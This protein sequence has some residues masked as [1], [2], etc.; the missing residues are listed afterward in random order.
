MSLLKNC[1]FTIALLNI[2]T[3]YPMDPPMGPPIQRTYP[4]NFQPMQFADDPDDEKIIVPNPIAISDETQTVF[5]GIPVQDLETIFQAAPPKAKCIVK[6][7]KS[8]LSKNYFKRSFIVGDSGTGKTTLAK[9]IAYKVC[10][11]TPWRYEYI[12]S[13]TFMGQYRN[14]TGVCLRAYLK[15][16]AELEQPVFL[17]IDHLNRILEYTDSSSDD[18]SFASNLICSLI[19]R[20]EHNSNIYFLGVMNRATRL[21]KRLKSRMLGTMIHVQRP[22]SL[23]IDRIV[24]TSKVAGH[25]YSFDFDITHDWLHSLLVNNPEIRGRNY[26]GVMVELDAQ[27][28]DATAAPQDKHVITKK[29]LEM[30]IQKYLDSKKQIY[31]PDPYENFTDKTERLHTEGLF[32]KFLSSGSLELAKKMLDE[33]TFFTEDQEIIIQ[34]LLSLHA[35]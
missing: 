31:Y 16:I 23:E 18:T 29:R 20:Q 19:D 33:G 12:N 26:R 34:Q 27:S 13:Q 15:K 17:I 25:G 1:I 22:D 35:Q 24:F 11:N 3:L 6:R 4:L 32:Q 30:A 21:A 5:D 28:S 14:Q 7:I 10:L 2:I 8:S 9:A